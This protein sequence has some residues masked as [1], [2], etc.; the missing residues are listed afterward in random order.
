M[1]RDWALCIMKHPA[2]VGGIRFGS[3]HDSTQR[4]VALFKRTGL[5]P[6]VIAPT[7]Q[8]PAALHGHGPASAAGPLVY[9]PEV[10]LRDHPELNHALQSLEVAIIP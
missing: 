2:N 1:A 10:L 7:L 6:A 4:N 3:R 8:P 9:G 5:T